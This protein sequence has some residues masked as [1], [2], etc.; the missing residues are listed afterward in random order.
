MAE[1]RA[2][3]GIARADGIVNLG[4]RLRAS[5]LKELLVQGL[6]AARALDVLPA[7]LSLDSVT[8]MPPIVDPNHIIGIGLNTKSHFEETMELMKR[9]AGDYPAYPRLFMR[10]AQSLVGHGQPLILPRLSTDYDFEGE[11]ALVIGK[12]CRYAT[13]DNALEYVGGVTCLNDGSVR[14][15]Q[16]H[17]SQVTAGKNF[18]SSGSVGPWITTMDDVGDLNALELVTRVNGE[19]RQRLVA[20]DLIFSYATLISYV[21]QIY[22]L[23]PGDLIATGSPAG[24]GVVTKRFLKPDDL[25][26]VEIPGIGKLSNRVLSESTPT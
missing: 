5:S 14:D 26:E 19:V 18:V 24:V 20:D 8:W 13:L 6:D 16:F 10:S 23:Q 21:S 17:S 7:D 4:A 1:G 3:Y 11:I 2:S 15:F 9:T 12:R 25:V 22:E